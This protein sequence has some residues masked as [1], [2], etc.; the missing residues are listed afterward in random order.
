MIFILVFFLSFNLCV[1]RSVPT[2]K[3]FLYVSFVF[4]F[5]ERSVVL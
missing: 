3:F 4:V 2:K 5:S 1:A